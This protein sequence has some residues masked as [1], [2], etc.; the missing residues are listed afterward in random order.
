MRGVGARGVG[1]TRAAAD[2]GPRKRVVILGGT[3]RVG[4]S[5]AQ[6]LLELRDVDVVLAG[7]NRAKFDVAMEECPKLA[8]AKAQF[9]SADA[10][11]VRSV[12]AAIEGADLVVHCAGPFQGLEHCNV[13]D[14]AIAQGVPYVDVSDDTAYVQRCRARAD[15]A[16]DAGVPCVTSTGIFP[17]ASN[18]M[19]VQMLDEVREGKTAEDAPS[20][21]RLLFSYFTAGSGGVGTT[22]LASTFLLASE[23]VVCYKDGEAVTVDPVTN[24]RVVDFGTGVGSREVFLYNLPEVATCHE[25]LGIPS[26]SARFGTSPG[27]WNGAMWLLSKLPRAVSR[28]RAF[29]SAMASISDPVV[30]LV[31][32][33]EGEAVAMRVEVEWDDG[34]TTCS[35]FSHKSLRTAVGAATAAFA[36]AALD[37]DTPPGVWVPE[38]P[39]AIPAEKRK[40]LLEKSAEPIG[41]RLELGKAPWRLASKAVQLGMGLYIDR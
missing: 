11:D 16:R 10:E 21:E 40:A 31:D 5:T 4:A 9:V 38:Q 29:A 37:G 19:A 6:R 17:G 22:I 27:V 13:L 35:V 30:R 1:A 14:A 24:R 8:E 26:V 18:V 2:A 7:R 23:E 32:R 3:G 28:S 34:S 12:E 41:A 39:E 33:I 36:D 25:T 20:P 15:K